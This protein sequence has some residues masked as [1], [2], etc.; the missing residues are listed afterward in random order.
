MKNS[1]SLFDYNW[2]KYVVNDKGNFDY[3]EI[4]SHFE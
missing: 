3:V 2:W 1:V 4:K